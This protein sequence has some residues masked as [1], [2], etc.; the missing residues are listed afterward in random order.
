[1]TVIKARHARNA[2]RVFL[3]HLGYAASG[4]GA[5]CRSI[6]RVEVEDRPLAVGL[7]TLKSARTLSYAACDGSSSG[8]PWIR[9]R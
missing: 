9:S 4:P 6:V 2:K 5:F 7:R 1:M 8:G 3:P